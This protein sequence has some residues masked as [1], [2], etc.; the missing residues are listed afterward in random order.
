[1]TIGII[2]EMIIEMTAVY[3][4]PLKRSR[5]S[6]RIFSL[7]FF[8]NRGLPALLKK[9]KSEGVAA[10]RRAIEPKPKGKRQAKI[11]SF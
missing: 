10:L 2:I 9:R 3:C 5:D 4:F 6:R 1:M 7:G 11:N 8:P